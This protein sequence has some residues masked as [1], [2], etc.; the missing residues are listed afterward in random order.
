MMKKHILRF[1]AG[2]S[3]LAVLAIFILF[4]VYIPVKLAIS[5]LAL[6]IVLLVGVIAYKLG[7]CIGYV[8]F[9]GKF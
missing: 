6:F 9:N 5:I 4:F 7:D 2:S 3:L 8:F 1:M